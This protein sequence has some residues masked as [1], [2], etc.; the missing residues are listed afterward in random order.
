MSNTCATANAYAITAE[1]MEKANELSKNMDL[2]TAPAMLFAAMS[3]RRAEPASAANDNLNIEVPQSAKG[4]VLTR[5]NIV[6]IE[7]YVSYG[8]LL[9]IDEDGVKKWIGYSNESYDG[10]KPADFKKLFCLI[11]GHAKEWSS[12]RADIKLSGAAFTQFSTDFTVSGREILDLI[13]TMPVLERCRGKVEDIKFDNDDKEIKK[14]LLELL[15]E[16]KKDIGTHKKK[17]SSLVAR[18]EKYREDFDNKIVPE[19]S[20]INKALHDSPVA[21]ENASLLSR[22]ADLQNEIK[23]L[24]AAYSKLVG[25]AFTG[26]AGM[27]IP[28]LGVISWA[29][30]GGVFGAKAEVVRKQR[31]EKKALL[32]AAQGELAE[33]GKLLSAITALNAKMVD[34]GSVLNEAAAGV[35]NLETVWKSIDAYIDQSVNELSEVNGSTRL[36]LFAKRFGVALEAWKNVGEVANELVFLF[37]AAIKEV[38]I[39]K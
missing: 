2:A 34:M 28:I 25:Y 22:I 6:A 27:V 9:P 17:S 18:I 14:I 23:A 8:L 29:V 20:K 5:E 12:L 33:K 10:M 7:R 32:E 39:Q 4:L 38:A 31:N 15:D 16:I 24:D 19:E 30:T 36:L 37:E 35:R 3:G 26:A 21:T 11:S 1:D 13:N